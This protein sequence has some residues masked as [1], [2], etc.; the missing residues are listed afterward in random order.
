MDKSTYPRV[1]KRDCAEAFGQESRKAASIP[2]SQR[3]IECMDG[4]LIVAFGGP[5]HV[6]PADMHRILLLSVPVLRLQIL[7][8]AT[9][10]VSARRRRR[11]KAHGPHLPP[12]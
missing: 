3:V 5:E 1:T 4:F 11:R 7:R 9:A 12:R 10:E 6:R 8:N 2:A